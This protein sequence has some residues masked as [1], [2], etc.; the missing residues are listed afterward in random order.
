MCSQHL[1]TKEGRLPFFQVLAFKNESRP[2]R[3][4]RRQNIKW[5]EPK[6]KGAEDGAFFPNVKC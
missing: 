6:R 4:Q 2:E 3:T 5:E 1:G